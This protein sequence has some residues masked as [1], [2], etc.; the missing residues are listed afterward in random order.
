[1]K[2][3]QPWLAAIAFLIC[4]PAFADNPND[5]FQGVVAKYLA[6]N[7]KP[8]LP[9]ETRKFKV[10]AE[11]AMQEKQFDKAAELYGKALEVAPWWPE[12]HFNRA[13]ILGETKK[14]WV[15]MREM[16]RYLLLV[17]DASNA[18]AAQDKIYQWE[19]VA[20]PEPTKA[21]ADEFADQK[22]GLIWRRCAEGM[23]YSGGTC[24]GSARTFTYEK[25]LQQAK[26]E[27]SRTSIAWRVPDRGE[28]SSVINKKYSPTIDPMTFP[29]VQSGGFFSPRVFLF[30]SASPVVGGSPDLGFVDFGDGSVG[31]YGYRSGGDFAVRLVR[32]GQ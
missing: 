14:Y 30:W 25:A 16:K 21:G 20:G 29:D 6:A 27:A 5:P 32:A 12:G 8:G 11:F 26:S 28:L 15:A 4:A 17:P 2:Y 9:E 18:R 3:I 23:V 10:Q 24:T 19:G 1:M 7:P 31:S 22:T 13:L